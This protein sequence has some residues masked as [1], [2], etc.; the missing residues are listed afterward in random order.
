MSWLGE[1]YR[2]G[3]QP[4]YAIN[5]AAKLS[6]NMIIEFKPLMSSSTTII[7]T[8]NRV[9]HLAKEIEV[10]QNNGKWAKRIIIMGALFGVCMALKAAYDKKNTTTP[11][12]SP[13]VNGKGNLILIVPIALAIL[14]PI[15]SAPTLIYNGIDQFT[16][17]HEILN[18]LTTK[19]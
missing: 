7:N 14:M 19:R 16:N 10:L 17:A 8:K 15:I 1:I 11:K 3:F 6:E 4:G 2:L 5:C 13:N 12:A 9:T 18:Q